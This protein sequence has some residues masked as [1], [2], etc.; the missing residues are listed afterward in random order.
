[1]FVV[2]GRRATGFEVPVVWVSQR[3]GLENFR[4]SLL[5]ISILWARTHGHK[6]TQL[7]DPLANKCP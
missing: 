2:Q 4:N 5:G 6:G 3:R 1:M 7:C